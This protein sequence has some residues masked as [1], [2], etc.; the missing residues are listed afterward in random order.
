[1]TDRFRYLSRW[2]ALVLVLL[3]AGAAVAR[4]TTVVPPAFEE[5]VLESDYVVHG[6]VTAVESFWQ[7]RGGSRVIVTQVRVEVL[8]VIAGEPPSPLVLT[9]LGGT[10]GE[11]SMV[12][13]GAP[14]FEVGDEDILFVQGN[15]RQVSP[16]TRIMHGRYRVAKD[17][18]SG[19]E[20]V[21]RDNGEPLTDTTEVA[22]PLHTEEGAAATATGEVPLAVRVERALSPAEF[23]QR[24]RAVKPAAN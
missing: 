14:Q 22:Q 18:A 5:L 3:G 19:R 2:C 10:V 20:F 23:V 16:L 4:S 12:L 13:E 21:A 17:V 8:E 15:G 7:E 11:Q 1:M 24:I 6:R 9:M